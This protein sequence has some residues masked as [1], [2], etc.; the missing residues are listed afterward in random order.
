MLDIL[1]QEDA[2]AHRHS[3]LSHLLIQFIYN[4]IILFSEKR[5]IRKHR[6]EVTNGKLDKVS[7]LPHI[8]QQGLYGL[9]HIDVSGIWMRFVFQLIM[10][11]QL[12]V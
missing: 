9:T 12:K 7:R 8:R 2:L 5:F 3:S 6:E 4:L 1:Y 11:S 10:D